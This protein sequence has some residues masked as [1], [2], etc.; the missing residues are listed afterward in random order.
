MGRICTVTG[1]RAEHLGMH[2]SPSRQRRA[3]TGQRCSLPLT[4]RSVHGVDHSFSQLVEVETVDTSPDSDEIGTGSQIRRRFGGDRAKTAAPAVPDHR[5]TDLA[6]DRVG[7]DNLITRL[8]GRQ[9][10][11][12][13]RAAPGPTGAPYERAKRVAP[14]NGCRRAGQ[15]ERRTRPLRR[16]AFRIAWPARVDIR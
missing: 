13:D 12:R 4:A 15:A 3:K 10:V 16:R 14:P 5:S 7:D 1:D 8:C 9:E 2:E 6:T 11:Y